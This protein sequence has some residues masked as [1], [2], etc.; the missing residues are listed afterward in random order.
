MHSLLERV[1]E[2]PIVL[3]AHVRSAGAEAADSRERPVPGVVPAGIRP[4]HRVADEGRHGRAS[5]AGEP[6]QPRQLLG[7][8]GDLCSLHARMIQLGRSLM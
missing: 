1:R 2:L 5:A 8:Q 7:G 6:L 3:H 4:V